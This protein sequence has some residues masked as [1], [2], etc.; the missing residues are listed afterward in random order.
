MGDTIQEQLEAV[1]R[2]YKEM[3]EIYHN[4]AGRVGL[5]DTSLWVLYALCASSQTYTQY[6]LCT[7][8]FYPKQTVNS[9]INHLVRDGFIELEPIKGTRN[10]KAVHLTDAGKNFCKDTVLPLIQAE[11]RCFERFTAE[12]RATLLLLQ[13]KQLTFFK[14]ETKLL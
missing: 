9:A 11:Q 7:E 6:D 10:R 8:W 12:E 5:S 2:Y 3:D 14:E 1:N 4:L 13:K